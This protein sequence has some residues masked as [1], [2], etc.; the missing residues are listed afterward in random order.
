M[1]AAPPGLARPGSDAVPASI[2][3]DIICDPAGSRA[4]RERLESKGGTRGHGGS[5]YRGRANGA[6]LAEPMESSARPSACGPRG[7]VAEESPPPDGECRY[8]G[9]AGPREPPSRGSRPPPLRPAEISFVLRTGR[10]GGLGAV[11]AVLGPGRDVRCGGLGAPVTP[12]NTSRGKAALQE[13]LRDVSESLVA[14]PLEKPG[15]EV[16]VMLR[17]V[18]LRCV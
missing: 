10:Q 8:V 1:V 13:P 6:V 4:P 3:Q 15:N 9:W 2:L 14:V 17:T 7:Y 16:K 5:G 11:A 18:F 12:R